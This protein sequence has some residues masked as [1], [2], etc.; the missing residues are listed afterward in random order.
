MVLI[1]RGLDLTK[2]ERLELVES[3]VIAK[4]EEDILYGFEG[5]DPR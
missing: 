2:H 4:K 1:G 5:A 3:G